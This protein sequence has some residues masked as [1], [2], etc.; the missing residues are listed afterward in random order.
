MYGTT[1][2]PAELVAEPGVLSADDPFGERA[3]SR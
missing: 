3:H 1:A 2:P